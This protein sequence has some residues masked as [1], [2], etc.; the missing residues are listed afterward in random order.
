MENVTARGGYVVP[1]HHRILLS[2]ML[3]TITLIGISGNTLI[4]IA[5]CLSRRLRTKTN[6]FL[7][8]LAAADILTCVFLPAIALPLLLDVEVPVQ[9]W[10]NTLCAVNY[11]AIWILTSTSIMT[12]AFI[13][14]N[15]YILITKSKKTYEQIYKRK[16]IFAFLCV[17]WLHPILYV[18][19]QLALG[20]LLVFGYNEKMHGCT[21]GL[22]DPRSYWYDIVDFANIT[23]VI[24]MIVYCY[25]RIYLRL[26][27]HNKQMQKG[28][29]SNPLWSER[30][31]GLTNSSRVSQTQ[32]TLTKN[33]FYILVAFFIC[34]V[35]VIISKAFN[36]NIIIISYTQV[37]MSFNCCLNPFIYGMKH[38]HFRQVLYYIL[39]RRW[40][41]IPEPAY[42]WM[43]SGSHSAIAGSRSNDLDGISLTVL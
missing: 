3:M 18:T 30:D 43:N 20:R 41:E 9:P 2:V 37:I 21:T 31:G 27:R 7:I 40:S 33:L 32:V 39:S 25:G 12:L 23:L 24:T 26:R 11:V 35:P 1:K 22:E 34:F 15:R 4:F 36:V 38:P 28:I 8:N 16:F 17:S 29:S 14:V 6:A 13:A 19:L 42:R 5:Y 10:L